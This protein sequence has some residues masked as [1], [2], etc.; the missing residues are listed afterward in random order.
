M[1]MRQV[2][3]AQEHL[4]NHFA[5]AYRDLEADTELESNSADYWLLANWMAKQQFKY[6]GQLRNHDMQTRIEAQAHAKY[7]KMRMHKAKLLDNDL[8]TQDQGFEIYSLVN[9]FNDLLTT[10]VELDIK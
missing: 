1:D 2:F 7:I 3:I 6:I 10:I 9:A 5:D 8:P 4:G